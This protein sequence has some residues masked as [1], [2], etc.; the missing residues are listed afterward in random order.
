[1]SEDFRIIETGVFILLE[2]MFYT[3]KKILCI[4][5]ILIII[6]ITFIML[7]GYNNNNNIK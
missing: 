7:K 3:F 1:M 4:S 5:N 2:R 6:M